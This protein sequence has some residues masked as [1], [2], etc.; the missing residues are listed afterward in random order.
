MA[1]FGRGLSEEFVAALN[2]ERGKGTWWDKIIQDHDL[3]VAVRNEYINVYYQGN[4]LVKLGFSRGEIVADVHYKYLIKPTLASGRNVMVRADGEM[5][6]ISQNGLVNFQEYLTCHLDEI[7]AIKK[8]STA[9]G[10]VEKEGIQKIL[11]SNGNIVDLEIALTHEDKSAGT[12]TAKRID[13]SALQK[14]ADGYE[15]VFFEVKDYGNAEL[16][17][18]GDVLPPVAREQIPTY[19]HLLAKYGADIKESYE[20]ICKNLM[21]LLPDRDFDPALGAIADGADFQVNTKPRL[22][23]FGFDADQKKGTLFQARMEKLKQA[24][25]RDR[26]LLKGNPTGFCGGISRV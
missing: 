24:L 21:A 15:L 12:K 19:E 25:G 23:V 7:S 3:F 20:H 17:A 8:A 26:V 14:T 18:G 22:V 6:F 5:Q 1:Y 16:K 10:G 2:D 11:K 13:F 9:Y 4:S